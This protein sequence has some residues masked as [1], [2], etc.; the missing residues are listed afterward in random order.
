MGVRRLG[1]EE[2]LALAGRLRGCGRGVRFHGRI[3]LT[4]PERVRI[5]D[6]V[7]VGANAFIRGE[8]GL[9]IG[10]NT[11]ISRNLVLYTFNHRYEGE[12]LP[13]DEGQV[14]GPVRIGRNVWIG[15]NVCITPGS[16]IGDGAIVGMGCV[17]MGEVPPLAIVGS[18]R[19]RVLG[20]RDAGHYGE[21]DGRGAYGG[22]DGKCLEGGGDGAG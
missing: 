12:R 18:Q 15:M 7:H 1:H 17:V 4:G 10:E 14:A 13:Y 2:M 21:L 9:E 5:G 20:W 16:V 11:H 3:T 19:W 22:A 8:G 6:N